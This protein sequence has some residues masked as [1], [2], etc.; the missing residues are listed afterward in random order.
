[1]KWILFLVVAASTLGG[2]WWYYSHRPDPAPQYQVSAVSR[3]DI[4]QSVTATGALN[5]VTNVTVGSQISG[6]IQS[7]GADWNTRVKANQVVAQLDPA[8]YL[9]A[10]QQAEGDLA[11]SRAN[12]ELAQIQARRA[13]EL[14]KDKLI[15]GSDH[16]TAVANLHQAQAVVQ[17]KQAALDNSKVNFSRC[18]IR[19]PVDGVVISRNVDVGQTVAA[20]LSAPTL[21][22]IANDLTQMQ[23]DASVAEA[24][25]GSIAEGQKVNFTV[26][27]FPYR[28]FGGKVVQVRSSPTTVQN[29]VTYDTVI[30]VNNDDL[31]LKP[32]MTANVSITIAERTN[33]LR[34]ANAALRFKLPE[35]ITGSTNSLSSNSSDAHHSGGAAAGAGG[36]RPRGERNVRNVYTLPPDSDKKDL[37][38]RPVQTQIKVGISDGFTT[39]V[40]DGLGEGDRVVTAVMQSATGVS[41]P[42]TNPFGGG[43]QRR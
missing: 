1:M 37:P 30:A 31:K 12:L 21:F 4:L 9:A 38:V 18:T 16:D 20:S 29:V 5:P 36:R 17:I 15:S 8:T 3:G 6:I 10:M 23:I 43:F 26:D 13:D 39:E 22:V 41:A 32:G 28:T 33:V 14:F 34:V 11:N 42:S 24:D 7:L 27:A 2:G 40:K 19:S 35:T 25:V